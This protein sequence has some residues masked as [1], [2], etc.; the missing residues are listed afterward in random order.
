VLLLHIPPYL[1][2]ALPIINN[3]D[4]YT[5]YIICNMGMFITKQKYIFQKLTEKYDFVV[6]PNLATK[7]YYP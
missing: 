4:S 7:E 3:L 2:K 1:P 5:N 6:V